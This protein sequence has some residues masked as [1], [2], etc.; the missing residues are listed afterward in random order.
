MVLATCAQTTAGI[1]D[2]VVDYSAGRRMK[3]WMWH[4]AVACEVLFSQSPVQTRFEHR[5][6][7]S[8]TVRSLFC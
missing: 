2:V 8:A 4:E 1:Q 7:G 3:F 6:D 5:G